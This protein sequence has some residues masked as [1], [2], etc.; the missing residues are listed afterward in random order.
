MSK[1]VIMIYD[2]LLLMK[3]TKTCKVSINLLNADLKF[4]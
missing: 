2:I 1:L 4:F 3:L